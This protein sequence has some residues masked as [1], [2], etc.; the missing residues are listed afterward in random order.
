VAGAPA[1]L[2]AVFEHAPAPFHLLRENGRTV[3]ANHAFEV[4]FGATPA[5][6]YDAFQSQN[7]ALDLPARL[8][9]AVA[10]EAQKLPQCERDARDLTQNP[11]IPA[12][13]LNVEL[14]LLPLADESGTVTHVALCF[15]VTQAPSA[16]RVAEG[17]SPIEAI[18]FAVLQA[19]LDGVVCA[20]RDGRIT[21]FNPAAER[22]FG[23][24]RAE[25]LGRQLVDLI[26]ESLRQRHLAGF[27]RYLETGV[28]P[29]LGK[30][31]EITA[32]H[33]SGREF[34]VELAVV[35][36]HAPGGT[37]FTAYIRDLTE[38]RRTAAALELSE[39]RFKRLFDS[40]L[41]G[42][43]ITDTTGE[44]HDA[45]DTFLQLVGYTRAELEA[46]QLR[47]P[48]LTPPE[49]HAADAYAV[50]QLA[51]RGVAEPWE[52][53]YIRRDGRRAPVLVGV[54]QVDG[55]RGIA[56]VLDLT[57][58]KLAEEGRRR[59]VATAQ[60]ESISRA[61]AEH[62]LERTAEQLRQSQKME[63]IGLLAGG[64]AHDF[65]NLLS[66]VLGYAE[67]LREQLSSSDPLR[68]DVEQISDAAGRARDLTRQLLAFGRRQ[69]LEPEIVSLNDVIERMARMLKRIIGED[70]ELSLLC[71]SDLSP[72]LVDPNQIEQV[73]LNLV[74]NARDAMPRGGKLT[75]ETADVELDQAYAD[76]HL[77]VAS[78][79]YVLLTVSD[80]GVG[81]DRATRERA[82]EPFFTTKSATQ[83]TGL[84]LSTAY[85]IVKQSGGTIW[86]YSE[87]GEGTVFKVYLP[88]ADG[89]PRPLAPSTRPPSTYRGDETVLLVED[90]DQVRGLA[91]AVLRRHGY[92]VLQAP[93]GGDALLIC[94]QH[95]GKI[96]LLLTDV[97]MP[98]MSGRELWERLSVLRPALKVLFMSGYTD[99]A[100]VRHGVLSSELAFVQKP[101]MPNLLL[102]KLRQVLDAG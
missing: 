81:M 86:L 76:R 2:A 71:K 74:V 19:A 62:A 36:T 51:I 54:A 93:T 10:G 14:T 72:T 69:V 57:A 5:A 85:G 90:D 100:V 1:A 3:F 30:R 59:A 55:P 66:V 97:V 75:I 64:I 4:A 39:T 43:M 83:G 6:T 89:H 22:T 60:A 79:P 92:Q 73:L 33:R 65:N 24:S 21:E 29:V 34:P 23:Y 32:L 18:T 31:V 15:G 28:G 26:P 49:W 50:E 70:I 38:H 58:Q 27:R 99:D 67:L 101:L 20:D 47:W 17:A 53:E 37:F 91:A 96:D 7:T 41:L 94:E 84:G 61:R 48:E 80:T 25:A 8:H 102:G 87:P 56:F 82:F 78:G 13:L 45:N 98:S 95:L 44:I 12:R 63:A 9:R 16:A 42:I 46:G 11:S 52:K 40:G 88:R 68:D 77:E 35:P